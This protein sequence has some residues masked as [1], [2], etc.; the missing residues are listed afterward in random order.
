MKNM[1][2]IGAA[3]LSLSL[4]A[5]GTSLVPVYAD[6][7]KVVTLGADLSDAQKQ[8]MLNYFKVNANDVQIM[9]ITNQDE[10]NHLSNRVP[11]EQIGTRTVSCAYIK[12]T[13]SGGIKVRTA[14]LNWVTGNMLASSLSTSGV[15]NCEVI[16]ACPF[17]VSGTGALTGVQMAYEQA[18]GQTLDPVKADIAVQEVIVTGN[19]SN[20]IG[21]T[22]AVNLINDSKI[23]IIQ[24]QIVDNSE[25]TNVVVNVANENN[26]N[27]SQEQMDE[28]V[29]LLQQIAD[30]QYNYEDVSD[31]L[32]SIDDSLNGS[33]VP[34]EEE[35][36]QIEV[37][38]DSIL[39]EIDE[40]VL[41]ED[42]VVSS[43]E[44]QSLEEE[45]YTDVPTVEI[46]MIDENTETNT[47]EEWESYDENGETADTEEQ[48]GED[49]TEVVEVP[50]E[51]ST[52]G[53]VTIPEGDY[54]TTDTETMISQLSEQS[55][56]QY[57]KMIDFTKGEFGGDQELLANTMGADFTVSLQASDYLTDDQ[58]TALQNAIA[59]NYLQILTD[60]GMS[61]TDDGTE[62][63]MSQELC[64]MDQYLKQLFEINGSNDDSSILSAL[65]AE[66]KELLYNDTLK[67]FEKMYGEE[68][69]IEW[70]GST[71]ETGTS[72]EY[73]EQT[74]ETGEEYTEE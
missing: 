34:T 44:D 57:D 66:Q 73:S 4:I 36:D 55:K 33:D 72:E 51:E 14:N 25:V 37:E 2:K 32:E 6:G 39:N 50:T 1:K 3:L 47:D 67:F 13:T 40:S 17:E 43:T 53:D 54:D 61:Y 19:L 31:T 74:E 5:G 12:P 26:L 58:I 18:T 20:E 28:V 71:E 59:K 7:N 49:N 62:G 70:E 41:G 69:V 48:N 29:N 38:E 22:D 15:K 56:S 46:E 11:V 30:Q 10:R 27:L 16:A 45:T 21:R 64:A 35:I 42:V 68:T 65:S 52:D 9:Y 63:Y 8:T 60:G 23:D 24:N